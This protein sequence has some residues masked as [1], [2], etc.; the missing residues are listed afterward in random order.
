MYI[1]SKHRVR[2]FQDMAYK[3]LEWD[4]VSRIELRKIF[5]I[6]GIILEELCCECNKLIEDR[7]IDLNSNEPRCSECFLKHN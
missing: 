5:D 2:V 4:Y 3:L 7:D 6:H 1:P